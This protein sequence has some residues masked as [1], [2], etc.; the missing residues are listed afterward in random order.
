MV[1]AG[2]P[3]Q[4]SRQ[5]RACSMDPHLISTLALAIQGVRKAFHKVLA[6]MHQD[7]SG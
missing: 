2:D 1:L 7:T 3:V 6:S 5:M 4:G